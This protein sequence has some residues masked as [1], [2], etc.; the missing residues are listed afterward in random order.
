MLILRLLGSSCLFLLLEQP[1]AGQRPSRTGG[2]VVSGIVRAE[3]DAPV[4]SVSVALRRSA[5]TVLVG[6]STTDST[7]AFRVVGVARGSD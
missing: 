6:A 4:G 3:Q 2:G 1:A 5:D 7:S